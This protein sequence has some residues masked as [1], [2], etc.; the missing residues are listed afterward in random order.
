MKIIKFWY[1][2]FRAFFSSFLPPQLPM[3]LLKISEGKRKGY[4]I[5]QD[6]ILLHLTVGE[7]RI[8]D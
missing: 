7:E 6:H 5:L 3:V 4:E 2:C 8:K 1:F